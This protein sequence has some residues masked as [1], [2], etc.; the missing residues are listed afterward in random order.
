[1]KWRLCF[2]LA[3]FWPDL[4]LDPFQSELGPTWA[5]PLGT[6]ALG[7]DGLLRL[8]HA[9][10]RSLGFASAA[11]ACD[12]DPVITYED[13]E[14]PGACEGSSWCFA[15]TT[16][17]CGSRQ[18]S[19]TTSAQRPW[20]TCTSCASSSPTCASGSRASASN[21]FVT[22]AEFDRL[23]EHGRALGFKYV[24]SG[25]LVR[26]SYRAGRLYQQALDARGSGAGARI[27]VA[28]AP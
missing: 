16:M 24:A 18:F 12:S 21:S 7:R 22:P 4:P 20:P 27:T 11:D 8:L 13:V 6:D 10:A 28:T 5:H 26:S 3:W 17:V 9:G 19:N 15:A 14:G 2:L 25:P 23:A 1:M